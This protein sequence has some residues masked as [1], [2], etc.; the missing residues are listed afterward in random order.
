MGNA[1]INKNITEV[2][3]AF[4]NE[5]EEL[6]RLQKLNVEFKKTPIEASKNADGEIKSNFIYEISV[7]KPNGFDERQKIAKIVNGLEFSKP[8]FSGYDKET[9]IYKTKEKAF[10]SLDADSI[11]R[12]LSGFVYEGKIGLKDGVNFEKAIEAVID[13]KANL[14]QN[15][16][17]EVKSKT[18]TS[19]IEGVSQQT[20]KLDNGAEKTA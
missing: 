12:V 6:F 17:S 20:L 15:M 16:L 14:L 19:L 9:P 2:E 8:V 11:K 3:Q 13:A 10:E 18:P 5:F 1:N 4:K 7:S